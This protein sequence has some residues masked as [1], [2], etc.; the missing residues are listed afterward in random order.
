MSTLPSAVVDFFSSIALAEQPLA[1]LRVDGSGRVTD[2]G[3]QL[4]R[5]GLEGVAGRDAEAS[6]DW[7]AG[8]V[9]P[10]LPVALPAVEVVEGVHAD[11]HVYTSAGEVWVVLVDRTS[12]VAERRF[13]QQLANDMSLLRERLSQ[14][15][16]PASPWE[17]RYAVAAAG[18]LRRA[19][20]LEVVLEGLST[21]AG[22]AELLVSDAGHYT[23]AVVRAVVDDAGVVIAATGDRL[24]AIFGA[25]PTTAPPG[26]LAAA[27]AIR[28]AAAVD[29]IGASLARDGRQ[30]AVLRAGIATGELVLGA[31]DARAETLAALGDALERAAALARIGAGV[32]I[33]EATYSELGETRSRF[34][35]SGAREGHYEMIR[36]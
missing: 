17:A 31:L 16:A 28:V 8:L 1:F 6:L 2:A 25:L 35:R 29:E 26:A 7:L 14:T 18:E 34:S 11:V 5:F 24:T 33:D 9:P 3:G 36:P 10:G 4:A 21:R 19:A 12:R 22:P 32:A 30:A 23:R 13:A 20:C 15:A 27:A